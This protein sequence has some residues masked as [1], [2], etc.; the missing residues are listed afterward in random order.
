[1]KNADKELLFYKGAELASIQ[2]GTKTFNFFRAQVQLL[3]E[4]A[5]ESSKDLCLLATDSSSSVLGSAGEGNIEQHAYSAYGHTTLSLNRPQ[6]AFNGEYLNLS[7][8]SYLLGAGVRLFS[9]VLMRFHA[10]DSMSPFS[11][12]GLNAYAYCLNDPV[13]ISDPTGHMGVR[14]LVQQYKIRANHHRA[15]VAAAAAKHKLAKKNLGTQEKLV[16]QANAKVNA[17]KTNAQ[18]S[19]NNLS[20][21][22]RQLNSVQKPEHDNWREKR[23]YNE[24]VLKHSTSIDLAQ[25]K[26]NQDMRALENANVRLHNAQIDRNIAMTALDN[27][28]SAHE[29]V[30]RIKPKSKT[31]YR[32]EIHPSVL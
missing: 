5:A 17:A 2:K 6:L 7:T 16:N 15:E 13:N 9:P 12:G 1:M 11:L 19:D 8:R 25:S 26:L 4:R 23:R 14:R 22:K 20:H 28:W 18:I 3:A 30:K 24:Q 31:S 32:R 21:L 27:A 10:P 29:E